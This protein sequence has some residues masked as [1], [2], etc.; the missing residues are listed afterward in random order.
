MRSPSGWPQVTATG[1]L[2]THL[3]RRPGPF[4]ADTS[5]IDWH[6]KAARRRLNASYPRTKL[7][8][9]LSGWPATRRREPSSES[10]KQPTAQLELLT[11]GSGHDPDQAASPR[12]LPVR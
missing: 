1:G 10:W 9:T 8:S 5:L 12:S 3:W 6:A 2:T 7:T 4:L 11:Y